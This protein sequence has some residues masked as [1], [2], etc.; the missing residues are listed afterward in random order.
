MNNL[1]KALD[2]ISPDVPYEQ[3][4]A[5]GMALKY[6]GY[7]LNVW[8]DWSKRGAKYASNKPDECAKKWAGFN[9]VDR[10]VTGGTIYEYARQAGWVPDLTEGAAL[11]W[12]DVIEYDGDDPKAE[13]SPVDQLIAYIE[14]LFEPDEYVSFV[15]DEAEQDA[16]GKWKPNGRG[17]F[18]TTAGELIR[19]LKAHPDDIAWT[20][21]DWKP[22]AGA[23]IRFNPLD[24][25]GVK[26]KN[27]T[28][29]RY[30]LIEADSVPVD[31]QAR[32]YQKFRLPIAALVESAGKSLHAIVHIDANDREEYDAR[33]RKLYSFLEE[34]GLQIDHANKNPARLSR[35][36]GATR[37]GKT[38]RLRGTNLGLSSWREWESWIENRDEQIPAIEWAND[39]DAEA[40][41]LAPELIEGILRQGHKLI[42]TS[43][44][45]AGKTWLVLDLA[46][47]ITRGDKWLGH[48]CRKGNVLYV[49]LEIDRASL[50]HRLLAIYEARH[51]PP[52]QMD[53]LAVWNLRGRARTLDQL[54]EPL[55]QQLNG[56]L[57]AGKRFAAIIIDPIYKVESG[58]E[59]SASDMA[60][61]FNQFDRIA[62]KTGCSVISI[63]HHSK[64]AQGAKNVADR[65]SGSGVFARDPDALLDITELELDERTRVASDGQKAFRMESVLREFPPIKPVDFWFDYPVYRFDEAGVLK[66]AGPKGSM[67]AARAASANFSTREDRQ[68]MLEAAYDAQ[69][70]L[71]DKVTISDIASYCG[72]SEK[73][74]RRWLD[75]SDKFKVENSVVTFVF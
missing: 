13:A 29:F 46:I 9:N 11:G 41:E 15:T 18:N 48:Q 69:A 50:Y 40:P 35:M 36:P 12:N 16:D 73:T 43:A 70:G 10:P 20:T 55:V 21:G 59:N 45:K 31:E 26:D 44:S 38:Q 49:N 28:R 62:D 1:L 37:N 53:G 14:T 6:E 58:D 68:E 2:A 47:A 56:M 51:Y 54:V 57:Q 25:T 24:G 71:G 72:K 74:V 33:V 23:W 8:E 7:T 52:H 61:F 27:V 5:V 60:K 42:I 17:D 64:G 63:H 22:E 30:T 34:H 39:I 67:E 65:G 4:L 32:V 66:H 19:K 3:W 75:E